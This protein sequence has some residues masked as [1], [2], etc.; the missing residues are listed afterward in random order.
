MNLDIA[1]WMMLLFII[2]MI[3]GMWKIYAFLPNKRLADE[4]TNKESQEE[5][6]KIM[7]K[8]I[9]HSDGKLTNQDLCEKIKED[10][11]FDKSHFW[12]FNQNRLNQLLALYLSQNPH[13][14]NIEDIYINSRTKN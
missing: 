3:I 10:E 1:T 6:L 2:F 13:V 11:E 9:K 8:V 4:D 7:L 5:L 14:K 12:R